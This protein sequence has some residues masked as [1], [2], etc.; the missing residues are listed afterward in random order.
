MPRT[1]LK[2]VV[3]F[4]GLAVGVPVSLAH[5]LNV[6]GQPVIPQL[7]A[8][9]AS[10]FTVTADAVNVTATRTADAASGAVNVYVEHWHTIESVTPPSNLVGLVPFV[11]ASGGGGGAVLFPRTANILGDFTATAFMINQVQDVPFTQ[12]TVTLPP[13]NSVPNGGWVGVYIAK[14]GGGSFGYLVTPG[15]GDT[16][17]GG[18]DLVINVSDTS[19][20]VNFLVSDGVSDWSAIAS[21]P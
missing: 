12:P 17:N 21:Y 1:T 18:T 6:N 16:L 4:A 2:N 9:N 20:A 11:I 7:V 3:A 5:G 8:A 19:Y 10:G 14:I 13:A 15:G